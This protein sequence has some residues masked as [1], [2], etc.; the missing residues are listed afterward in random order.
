ML[1]YKTIEYGLY[2]GHDLEVSWST[3]KGNI[4]GVWHFV[5]QKDMK[6]QA[7]HIVVRLQKI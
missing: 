4:N 7:T 1:I 3:R 5:F 2:R 6:P